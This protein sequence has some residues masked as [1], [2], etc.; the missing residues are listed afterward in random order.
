MLSGIIIAKNEENTISD[1]VKSLSF[2]D[3]V[4]VVNNESS[5]KTQVL[6]EKAG[7]RVIQSQGNDFSIHRKA[8]MDAAREEWVIY[9]D[10]DERISKELQSEI[11]SRIKSNSYSAYKI[12]RLDIFWGKK[13]QH[14]EVKE[15]ATK[16]I[17]RLMKKGSGAWQNSVHEEFVT[18]APV[19]RL[20]ESLIHYAHTGITDFLHDIN[21]YSTIRAEELYK[22]G[23]HIQT[24]DL[25]FKPFGKFLYTYFLLQGFRDGA[26]GFTYSFMMSFHSFLVRSKIYLFQEGATKL[27]SGH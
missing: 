25:I 4:I 8:G 14:G 3:E 23:E 27:R 5:D 9:V 17:A 13:L 16:G 22:K 24:K 18:S 11:I 19:G 7:A 2:C 12:P 21:E 15:A 20:R 6:A 10:A 1:L 26:A